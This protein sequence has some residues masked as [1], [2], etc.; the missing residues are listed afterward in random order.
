MFCSQGGR[1]L[2][3][4]YAANPNAVAMQVY[5][6]AFVYNGMRVAQSEAA[7]HLDWPPE[8]SSPAKFFPKLA[9]ACAPSVCRG[10]RGNA[11][12]ATSLAPIRVPCAAAGGPAR[13]PRRSRSSTDRSTAAASATAPPA[14]SGNCR[15]MVAVAADFRRRDLSSDG[16]P[17]LDV[18]TIASQGQNPSTLAAAGAGL[19][20]RT[21]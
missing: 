4:V 10:R 21:S 5:A 17:V 16:A 19:G 20:R 3:R 6:A 9:V 8:D 1:N 14:V 13:S 7:T 18:A 11:S 12:S 2:N 15:P